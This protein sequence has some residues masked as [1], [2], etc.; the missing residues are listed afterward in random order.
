MTISFG[1]LKIWDPG[2]G[3]IG[4]FGGSFLLTGFGSFDESGGED[5]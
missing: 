2:E 5:E 4:D 1:W 3:D